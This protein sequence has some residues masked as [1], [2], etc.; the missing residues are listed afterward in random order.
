M[1]YIS[2]VKNS[3][4]RISYSTTSIN[5]S[6]LW[7]KEKNKEIKEMKYTK[8]RSWRHPNIYMCV[9]VSL[10]TYRFIYYGKVFPPNLKIELWRINVN[11]Y[12]FGKSFTQTQWLNEINGSKIAFIR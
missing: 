8:E 12:K 5:K 4:I 1:K 11:F 7:S 9:H 10:W 6:H 3:K 2:L